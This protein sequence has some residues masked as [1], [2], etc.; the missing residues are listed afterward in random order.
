MLY[1]PMGV[2]AFKNTMATTM[3]DLEVVISFQVL[4]L[5]DAIPADVAN[6]FVIPLKK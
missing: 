2:V 5:V 3:K 4:L 1:L 6:G